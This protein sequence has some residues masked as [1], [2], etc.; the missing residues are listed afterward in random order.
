M[1]IKGQ[2]RQQ[3]EPGKETGGQALTYIARF[4]PDTRHMIV[5]DVPA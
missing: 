2:L 5:F 4:L 1:S 3:P